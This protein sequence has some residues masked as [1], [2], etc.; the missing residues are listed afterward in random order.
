MVCVQAGKFWQ[1]L[2]SQRSAAVKLS[3]KHFLHGVVGAP[4]ETNTLPEHYLTKRLLFVN[5]QVLEEVVSQI[6][7]SFQ[8]QLYKIL[9]LHQ[10]MMQAM[11]H[12]V[13]AMCDA[14]ASFVS[15]ANCKGI[16]L[17]LEQPEL[18]LLRRDS[19]TS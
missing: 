8:S 6:G 10:A 17:E 1:I 13:Y 12:T 9:I 19:N 14:N 5:K 18:A 15:R 3:H 7:C 2:L 4:R 11:H 16:N